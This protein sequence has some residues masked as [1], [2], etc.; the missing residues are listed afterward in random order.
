MQ[1]LLLFVLNMLYIDSC[2][3]KIAG[4]AAFSNKAALFQS[5]ALRWTS[6][7]PSSGAI[8]MSF[9]VVYIHHSVSTG[10]AY[11]PVIMLTHRYLLTPDGIAGL[12]N[13]AS[14]KVFG[15]WRH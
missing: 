1:F 3:P 7:K 12:V 8:K 15:A 2:S 10:Q 11:P 5:M 9:T 13:I 4:N 14:C 6:M